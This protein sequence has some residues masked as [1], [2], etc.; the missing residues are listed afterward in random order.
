MRTETEKKVPYRYGMHNSKHDRALRV[1]AEKSLCLEST[2]NHLS[3]PLCA[4][5][6]WLIVGFFLYHHLQV[7]GS[8]L[9]G[10]A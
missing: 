10:C 9:Y 7:S 2:W 5:F 8:K 3:A 6:T 4:S 1:A